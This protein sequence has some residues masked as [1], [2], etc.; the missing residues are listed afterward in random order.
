VKSNWVIILLVIVS[1][2]SFFRKKKS[3]DT[4]VIA[5]VNDEYLYA[6]DVETLTRGL[7][8]K[9]SI[10]VLRNYAESWVRK[11]L[12]LQKATDNIAEEDVGITKKVEDYRENLLLYEYEKALLSQ[13]LDT[14]FTLAELDSNYE[15]MKASYPLPDDV[16]L[17][18]YVKL[19]KDAPDLAKAKKWILNPKDEEAIQKL[20]GYCKEFALSSAMDNGMWVGKET[21]LKNFPVNENEI[22]NLTAGKQFKEYKTDEADWFIK[23]AEVLKKDEPS[24]L[25]FVKEKVERVI[26]EKRKMLLIQKIYDKIYQDGLS[27]KSFEIYLRQ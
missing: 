15:K 10:D 7:K 14:A 9:D 21:A 2:C 5:R 26:I 23:I 19:K 17:V 12:L 16:Y 3:V 6:S 11:K 13:K 18:F 20:E 27:S 24:P 22:W 8:G 4:G 25:E 1:S